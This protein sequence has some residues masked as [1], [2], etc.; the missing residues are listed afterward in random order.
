MCSSDLPPQD[1]SSLGPSQ[2]AYA[3]EQLQ[4]QAGLSLDTQYYLARQVHPVVGRICEP[5]EGIDG[6]LIATWLGES[7]LGFP[8]LCRLH[9]SSL[10]GVGAASQQFQIWSRVCR[11]VFFTVCVCGGQAWTRPSSGTRCS[12]RGRRRGRALW[13]RPPS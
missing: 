8:A 6:V 10:W 5:I 9:T 12:T 13:A 4:K 1:G 3:L 2:R 7:R 11:E